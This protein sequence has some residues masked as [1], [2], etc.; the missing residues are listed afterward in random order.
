MSGAAYLVAVTYW[1]VLAAEL[2][3]DKAIYTVTSLV[4]RFPI[5]PVACGIGVAFSGKIL[6]AVLFGNL[7]AQ[8]PFR[9]TAA[10]SAATFFFTAFMLW[11]HPKETPVAPVRGRSNALVVSFAAI[12][13]SEWGDLGQVATAALVAGYHSP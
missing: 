3:G 1:T 9:V 7:L 5:L 2:V 6:I 13:F 11:R 4:T 8:F 10:I 12:F